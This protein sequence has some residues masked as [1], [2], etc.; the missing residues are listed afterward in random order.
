MALPIAPIH[1]GLSSSKEKKTPIFGE[2]K[3]KARIAIRIPFLR[4]HR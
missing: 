4:A 3:G 2:E 1:N